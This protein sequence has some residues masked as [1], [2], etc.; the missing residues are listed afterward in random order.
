MT[1]VLTVVCG[2]VVAASAIAAH[3]AEPARLNVE[4]LIEE[5]LANNPS[6]AVLRHRLEASEARIP[7]VRALNDPMIALELSNVPLSDFDFN[8]TPMSGKRLVL[9]QRLPYWGKRA[10]RGEVAAREARVVE[11]G[12]RDR[13]GAIVNLVKQAYLTLHFLDRSIDIT[14]E[15]RSLIRDFIRIAQT[16]YAVGRGLQQD[17]LK[18]Q[19][20]LSK[21]NVRLIGLR[22]RRDRAAAE[23]NTTL[24]RQPQAL[25]GRTAEVVT[26]PGVLDVGNLQETAL[27]NRPLLKGIRARANRWRAEE[28]LAHR[29]SRPDFDVSVGYTQRDFDGDPVA[30]SDFLSVGVQLNLPIFQGS[31][32]HH[33]AMAARARMRAAEA[34]YEEKRQQ[35]FLQIQQ[36]FIDVTAHREE[37]ALYKTAII[38]QAEQALASAM[39]GY[40]VGKVDFLTLLD[41]QVTLFDFET[42]YYH[43]LTEY[44][45]SLAR[46]EAVVGKR[47]F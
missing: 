43:H 42:A 22:Q 34:E 13:E 30:G 5:A 1:R 4:R 25:L 7:Q 45:K 37:A 14:E 26:T 31:M 23:L 17:V 11:A 9:R 46:L 19:V 6:L 16:K 2:V 29:E 12:L 21:L 39:A 3:G 47:L 32:H 36:L 20:S 28:E 8:S 15:N 35:V 44:E 38:P 10:A 24:N 27:A 18:A 40:Q 41:N 33:H